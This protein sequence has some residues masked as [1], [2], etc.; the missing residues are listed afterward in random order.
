MVEKTSCLIVITFIV[1]KTKMGSDPNIATILPHGKRY[2][3]CR[4]HQVQR[5]AFGRRQ[6]V[7]LAAQ[8]STTFK[9]GRMSI[10]HINPG[11][12]LL[13]ETEDCRTRENGVRLQYHHAHPAPASVRLD[14]G[15]T[16]IC[17]VL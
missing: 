17:L 14:S 2:A 7:R 9:A 11:E 12:F 8:R 5:G 4:V 1:A 3:D 15:V 13:Y 16:S 10:Q 6:M